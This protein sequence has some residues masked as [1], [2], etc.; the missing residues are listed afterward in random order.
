MKT[1]TGLFVLVVMM[2][3]VV[4]PSRGD[5]VIDEDFSGVVTENWD[6]LYQVTATPTDYNAVFP[7]VSY[8]TYDTPS[9]EL[10][11]QTN[12]E[13]YH[14]P[15]QTLTF[16]NKTAFTDR[17]FSLSADAY[18]AN[19]DTDGNNVHTM[20]E[21][22]VLSDGGVGGSG[23][24]DTGYTVRWYLINTYSNFSITNRSTGTVMWNTNSSGFVSGAW[25]TLTLDVIETESGLTLDFTAAPRVGPGTTVTQML[26]IGSGD[27]EYIGDGGGLLMSVYHTGNY[28]GQTARLDNI[29]VT[30]PTVPEPGS[31]SMMAAVAATIG[32]M[33]IRK[34]DDV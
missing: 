10:E 14:A 33:R 28:T 4:L 26:A 31:M 24:A 32:M 15:N 1:L 20:V 18:L 34:K 29:T 13:S 17:T 22:T 7:G 3:M 21:F 2:S 5:V 23:L 12:K 11:V 25:Y 27:G 30:T 8:I 9:D 6:V 16:G 19:G